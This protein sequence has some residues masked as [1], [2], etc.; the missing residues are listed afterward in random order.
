MIIDMPLPM[1]RWLII[2]PNHI[3]TAAPAT[4]VMITR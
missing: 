1:P 2:S 3:S 4:S